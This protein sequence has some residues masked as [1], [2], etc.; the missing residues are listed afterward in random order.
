[1]WKAGTLLHGLLIVAWP[2]RSVAAT[3][4]VGSAPP[5]RQEVLAG[6]PALLFYP[7]SPRP[8]DWR[9]GAGALVDILPTRIVE[10]EQRQIPQL[11]GALRLGLPAHIAVDLRARAILIQNQLEAGISWSF[12]LGPISFAVQNHLGPWFGFVDL[13]GFDATAWGLLETPGV[14]VGVPWRDVRFALS[15]EAIVSFAQH[16]T[17]GDATKTSRQDVTFSGLVTTLVVETLL[18]SGGVP[19]FG[20]GLLWTQP[21]YQAWLAFSDERARILYPR[22]MA[23][24]GF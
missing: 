1:M 14:A 3:P 9:A 17:L 11:T 18:K 16:T 23:G 12:R 13:D 15:S 22:F 20:V 8:F 5:A 21:D 10:S 2:L 6:E 7:A 24:Y 4:E 19:Y